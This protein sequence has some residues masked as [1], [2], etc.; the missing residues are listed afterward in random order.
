MLVL[1]TDGQAG[2]RNGQTGWSTN[3]LHAIH[4]SLIHTQPQRRN[5]EE[6][7]ATIYSVGWHLG[8]SVFEIRTAHL[9]M[10]TLFN[11]EPLGYL[12]DSD[13]GGVGVS[14]IATHLRCDERRL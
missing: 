10:R 5:E 7:G 1:R 4:G 2:H 13:Y 9:M 12:V 8:F 6:P 3:P 11:G 14:I